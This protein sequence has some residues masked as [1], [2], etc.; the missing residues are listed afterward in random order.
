MKKALTIFAAI[1]LFSAT[2][3]AQSLLDI[4]KG[5]ASQV[6]SDVISG[7]TTASTIELEGTW[8]YNGVAV[9]VDAGNMFGNIA[10]SAVMGTVESK[11]DEYLAKVGI[12]PG[13]ATLS[14]GTDYTFV[15]QAG[16]AKINGTWEQVGD[17]VTLKFGKNMTFLKL[18]GVVKAATGGCEVLFD[19]DKFISFAEKAASVIASITGE[20]STAAT[21]SGLLNN[22]KGLD[23]GF[24]LVK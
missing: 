14:F 24:K 16:K 11:L 17:K 7:T 19:A 2:A 15:L 4:I 18:E 5:S 13:V 3:G 8:T 21:I 10:S 22:V 9:G 23:A 12:K 1:A 20:N 6:L